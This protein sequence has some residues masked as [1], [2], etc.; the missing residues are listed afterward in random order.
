VKKTPPDHPPEHW[1]KYAE[2]VRNRAG[3]MRTASASRELEAIALAYERLAHYA[4]KR[5]E[6]AKDQV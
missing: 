1:L 6:R 3:R 5:Q 2:E 4:A